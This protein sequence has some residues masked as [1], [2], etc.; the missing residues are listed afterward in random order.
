MGFLGINLPEEYGG[1][2]LCHLEAL[3]VLEQFAMISAAVAWPIFESATGPVRTVQ[4]FASDA[5]KAR[6][7]PDVIKGDKIVAVSMS[8]PSAG[9]A[10]TDRKPAGRSEGEEIRS[11]ERRVGEEGV[12]T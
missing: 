2:G 8:E 10:L 11:D 9:T 3:L 1:R 5:L 6:S 7:I 4:H 12:S